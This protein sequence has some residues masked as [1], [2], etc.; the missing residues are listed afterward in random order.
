MTPGE[1]MRVTFTIDAGPVQW[2]IA[3]DYAPG[4]G[5]DLPSEEPEL[6][7][8]RGKCSD[9]RELVGLALE[10]ELDRAG[11]G[12]RVLGL[13]RAAHGRAVRAQGEAA[14]RRMLIGRWLDG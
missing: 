13:A 9:G 6:D 8:L 12:H 1:T 3:A 11:V 5:S 10:A 7:L 4:D 14:R 2:T